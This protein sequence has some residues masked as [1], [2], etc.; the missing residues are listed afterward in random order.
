MNPLIW[1]LL[2][3][4][5]YFNLTVCGADTG[6]VC[7]EKEKQ[8]LL[9][10]KQG[11]TDPSGRLSSWNVKTDCCSWMGVQCD[12]LTGQ[13]IELRLTNPNNFY[14]NYGNMSMLG[15]GISSALL[16]LESLSYL[17]LS[18][19]NFGGT[20]I[21]SFLGFMKS[22]KHLDLRKASFGGLIPHQLGNLSGILYLDMGYND[23]LYVDNLSWVANLHN[24]EFLD[25]ISINIQGKWIQAVSMLPS[26]SE[27][28]L[29]ECR[30]Q[31][32][33]PSLGLSF[34]DL[35]YDS[36][37]GEVPDMLAQL[38]YLQY[39]DLSNNKLTGPF[40]KALGNLSSLWRLAIGNNQLNGTL[41]MSTGLPSNLKVLDFSSNHFEEIVS[42]LNFATLTKLT[43]VDISF[44]SLFFNVNAS[45]IPPFQLEA[46]VSVSNKMGPSFP[47]WLRTQK[48]LGTLTISNSEISD[49]V[50]DWF[51]DWA[52]S[53]GYW[54][55]I[56]LSQNNIGGSLS[57]V[58][59]NSTY[60]D[61]S[62]NNFTGQPPQFSSNVVMYNVANNA[63]SGNI[64]SFLCR[65]SYWENN[66]MILDMEN[67][68]MTGKLPGCWMYWS[69]LTHLNLGLID[70]GENKFTGVIP[71]WIGD[72]TLLALR[73]TSNKF[74]GH[75]PPQ[76]CRLSYMVILDLS[77]NKLVGSI[78]KC[79]NNMSDMATGNGP[80]FQTY[81]YG[82]A[83]YEGQLE[84]IS[85][86]AKLEY[87][88]EHIP[89]NVG[90]MVNLESLDLSNN[91]LTGEIPESMTR[92]TFLGVLDLSNN[93]LWGKIPTSTQLQGFNET[94]FAGNA[95]LCGLP[96]SKRCT[97]QSQGGIPVVD[98]VEESEIL[99][100][101]KGMW[102]GFAAGF[103]GVCA[104][105]FFNRTWRHAYFLFLDRVKDWIYVTTV[106]KMKQ[107]G[108]MLKRLTGVD[109]K[110]PSSTR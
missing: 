35:S 18:G 37:Y 55:E 89:E 65:A 11:L 17:D 102:P 78:P 38:E 49:I 15:G 50:P 34:L 12:N 87:K 70:L 10:F 97:N 69:S 103:F 77:N 47:A 43:F 42:E 75:I 63:L 6:I 82:Y 53:M 28:Y 21:P 26:L 46:F 90:N 83:Y 93:N 48:S 62:S 99:W 7:S 4:I 105:L 80:P 84:L 41:P 94:C 44:N 91:N 30:L 3:S 51:W 1:L 25:L 58:L 2:F 76:I 54:S 108:R 36:I 95:E 40:P 64:S 45:W 96:L 29:S 32:M 33:V 9:H 88:I 72:M 101:Y 86:G 59:L 57:H 85:K 5:A 22:L 52:S 68:L 13:V 16:E 60:V 56:D 14:G 19:N 39:L 20:P 92:L 8:A 67:N 23:A 73:L 110:L 100:F 66:V 98:V 104:S 71:S 106:I 31:S 74:T 79:L 109:R 81:A 61:L 27:L 24:L 107:V